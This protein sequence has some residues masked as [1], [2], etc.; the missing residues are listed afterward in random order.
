MSRDFTI[1]YFSGI[2]QGLNLKVVTF[3]DT[4]YIEKN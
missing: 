2:N 4:S 3:T 1:S